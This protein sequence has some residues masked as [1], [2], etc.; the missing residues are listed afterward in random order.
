MVRPNPRHAAERERFVEDLLDF[1]TRDEKFGQLVLLPFGHDPGSRPTSGEEHA[2]DDQLRRGHVTGLSGRMPP[3]EIA[4]L[5]RIAIEETRLGIPLFFAADC[6]RG[7]ETLMPSL[8]AMSASWNTDSVETAERAIAGE[9]RLG[10]YNWILG[11]QVSLAGA[12]EDS[13]GE[14]SHELATHLAERIAIAQI[15]GIQ[16]VEEGEQKMLACL[17]IDDPAWAGR[18]DAQRLGN[19]LHLVVAALRDAAPG[20]VALGPATHA[21]IDIDGGPADPLSSLGRPGGYEGIDLSEWGEFARLSRQEVRDPPFVGL[22]VAALAAAVEQERIPIGRVDDAVRR[23]LAAKF[24]LG[25][26]RADLP[27]RIPL[28]TPLPAERPRAVA[29]DAARRAIVLLRN[30]RGILPLNVDSGRILVV[31]AAAVDRRLPAAFASGEGASLVDGLDALGLAHRFVPGLALRQ[32]EGTGQSDRLIEADRMAIGMAAEAARR[33]QTVIVALGETG[34]PGEARRMLLESLRAANRNIIL[35]TL[36]PR[37][38][39]PV[40]GGERLPCLLHAGQL[41]TMSG[42][43]IAQVLSGQFAPC[44]RLAAP[45]QEGG[46]TILPLGHGLGYSEFGLSDATAELGDDRVLLHAALHN[47]G[48]YEGTETVQLYLRR[49]GRE[50]RRPLELARFQQISVASGESRRLSFD[51]GASELG[52]F[53][54]DGRHVVAAGIYEF[55]LGLSRTRAHPIEVTVPQVVVDAMARR[56]AGGIPTTLFGGFR[57]TGS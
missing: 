4:R 29:L 16:R 17:R 51:L 20:S 45:V 53:E 30:E 11:P 13:S 27:A 2:L 12:I 42:H 28:S 10:G 25:L 21:G 41:G 46:K 15:R 48:E 49:P 56:A 47:V 35:V 57:R 5:Q 33:S 31:G 26:F 1:M 44:G 38:I 18:R 22:S 14:Q 36:G 50:P 6:A 43:A 8:L 55:A 40:V 37:I 52:R 24:D 39:D 9:A 54:P 3:A 34:A 32:Q 7:R 19:K 23:V